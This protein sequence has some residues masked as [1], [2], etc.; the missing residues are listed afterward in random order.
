VGSLSFTASS[1]YDQFQLETVIQKIDELI[2]ALR[3]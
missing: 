2:N 3:R 1:T